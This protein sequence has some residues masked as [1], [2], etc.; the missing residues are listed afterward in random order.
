MEFGGLKNACYIILFIMRIEITNKK[1]IE[2]IVSNLLKKKPITPIE[3]I[4]IHVNNKGFTRLTI[5]YDSTIQHRYGE[6]N[7]SCCVDIYDGS[8]HLSIYKA[9]RKKFKACHIELKI[10]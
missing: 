4:V 1:A 3:K 2:Q 10:N 9:T 8:I 7:V 5:I 6:H